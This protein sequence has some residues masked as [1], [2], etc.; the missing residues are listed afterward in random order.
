MEI[1]YAYQSLTCLETFAYIIFP[2]A[3]DTYVIVSNSIRYSVVQDTV[4]NYF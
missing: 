1:I 3:L 4:F 2:G